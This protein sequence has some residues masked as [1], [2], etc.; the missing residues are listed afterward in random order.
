MDDK[1][2]EERL[3]LLKN[4]YDRLP[5]S[6]N[7]EDV[8]KMIEKENLPLTKITK[9]IS[10]KWQNVTI[11]A[12]SMACVFIIGILGAPLI[13]EEVNIVQNQREEE[14]KMTVDQFI[15]KLRFNPYLPS[16][17][18]EEL[19][20]NKITLPEKE[21]A[22]FFDLYSYRIEDLKKSYDAMRS[23]S[24]EQIKMLEKEWL[25]LVEG[26]LH[27]QIKEN[28]L[29]NNLIKSLAPSAE[30]YFIM[31]EKEPFTY[32]GELIYSIEDSVAL[33]FLFENY[34]LE[35]SDYYKDN[36]KMKAAYTE[37]FHAVVKGTNDQSIYNHDGTVKQQY[38][39]L[40][41]VMIAE[42]SNSP[43]DFLLTPIVSE[44]EATNWV[45][46]DS[47]AKLDYNDIDDALHL[48]ITGDL[49]KFLEYPVYDDSESLIDDDFVQNVHS[50][51]KSFTGTHDQTVLK[52]A[53]AEEI[54]GLYYY[55]IQLEDDE[56]KYELYIKDDQYQQIP[57][58]EYMNAPKQK[59]GDIRNEISS[60][61]FQQNSAEEGVAILTLHPNQTL[62]TQ[63]TV[64]GFQLIHTENGWRAAFMPTQ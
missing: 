25:Y 36:D 45:Q 22:Q 37:I 61:R 48:A 64:I 43:V 1:Q 26:E 21:T 17:M 5:H 8:I 38:R 40:W 33:M 24:D 6:L 16:E 53:G 59:I 4:S 60:I 18:I 9:N 54:V 31:L 20:Q 35:S 32:A 12:I 56:T 19:V 51:Y 29:Y 34:L 44:F 11:W 50:L 63:D 39:E 58:E 62:Y 30:G 14:A 41:K 23:I 47:W 2:L 10:S 28:D 7:I 57:K 13:N 15:Q 52:D 42:T 27:Y 3:D 49:E 46:S 55:C